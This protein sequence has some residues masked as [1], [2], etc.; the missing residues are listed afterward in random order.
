MRFRF[1]DDHREAWPVAVLCG[2]LQVSTAGYYPWRS[3]P[4]G[5]RAAENRA[6]V[7]DIG[8]VHEASQGS[9]GSP[10]VHAALRAGGKEDQP[11]PGGA[12]YAP[13]RRAR[14][15]RATPAGADDGQ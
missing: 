10:R 5:K 1:I 14:P 12:D 9:Y 11:P 6:L 3:R 15:R 8:Q 4:E 7:D 2:V 13:P